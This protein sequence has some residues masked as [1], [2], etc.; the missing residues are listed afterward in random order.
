MRNFNLRKLLTGLAV[1]GF[2]IGFFILAVPQVSGAAEPVALT[3]TGD[4]VERTVQFTWAELEALP[5]KTYTYSGY[6]HWPSLNVFKDATGPTLKTI[7]DVAGLKDNA[8]LIRVKEAGGVYSD[9][10]REQLL[11]SVRYYFPADENPGDVVEWPPE[12]SEEG[13]VPVETMLALNI[14]NGK[15]LF[16]QRSPLEPTVCKGLMIDDVC[17]GGTIEV[18]TGPLEQWEAPNVDI[19]PGTVVPGTEVKLQYLDGTDTRPTVYYTL[20]G[21]EPTYGSIIANISYPYFQPE[22]NAPIPINGNVTIKA[23]T[24]GFGKLDSEVVTFEYNVGTLA[25]TIEGA[26]LSKPVSYT[27]ETLK[28]MT[29]AEGNYQCSEQGQTVSVAGE[30][31][32]LGTLLDQ[33]NVSSR[34]DVE[35]ITAGGE[36]I[37]AGTVQELK[38]QQCM[39]AYEVNGREIADVSGDETINIQILR[40]LNDSDLT[41]NRLKYV[42][43]IKLISVD[44]EITISNVKLLDHNGQEISSVAAGGGYS[45]E[46]RFD[47]KVNADKN[48]LLVIQVRNGEGATETTGGSVVGCVAA[49]TVVDVAGGQA[50]AEFTMPGNVSG[51]AYVDVFVWDNGSSHHPL[52]KDNHE[53][54]FDVE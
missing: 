13:K 32:L 11:D 27:I 16:G 3:V 54:S 49:Q 4:G 44:D 36:K 7:L 28:G 5:Q 37:E 25:C 30:G 38:D 41:G 52:G 43:T 1:L 14:A 31:V 53:V 8:K 18:T 15:L 35:F 20:D 34:W 10:T 19:A 12:R 26:G 47:N 17:A 24:I 33:L 42:K 40:N 48:A 23:R 21:T 2:I 50:A 9:Y 6:N 46:A 51:K 29:P 39:L 45:I 22:L